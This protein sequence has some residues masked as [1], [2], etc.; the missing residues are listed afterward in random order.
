M[1]GFGGHRLSHH[2][3]G[4]HVVDLT[5]AL[6]DK[7]LSVW[8]A[9]PKPPSRPA[10]LPDIASEIAEG[11]IA[12]QLPH[13]RVFSEADIGDVEQKFAGLEAIVS[14]MRE[15]TEMFLRCPSASSP[16]TPSRASS[17]SRPPSPCSKAPSCCAS[18]HAPA[19]TAV[20]GDMAAARDQLLSHVDVAWK[21]IRGESHGFMKDIFAEVR[22][23]APEASQEVIEEVLSKCFLG[24]FAH[25]VETIVGEC[26][27]QFREEVRERFR[28]Q[29]RRSAAHWCSAAPLPCPPLPAGASSAASRVSTPQFT[30]PQ[31]GALRNAPGFGKGPSRTRRGAR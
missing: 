5:A 11:F 24:R 13:A 23:Q 9:L 7:A 14:E 30:H 3:E 28:L 8:D 12:Q 10:A 15:H 4:Q 18:S 26:P 27:E 2:R 20:A 21:K 19:Q 29:A 1:C 31:A 16:S 25:V 17:S 6:G 22:C